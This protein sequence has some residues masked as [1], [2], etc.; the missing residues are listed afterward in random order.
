MHKKCVVIFGPTAV[1]KSDLAYQIA[2]YCKTEIISA[3]SRQCFRELNIGV[4][5]PDN[6]M[7]KNIPHHFV[8][9][10]SIHDTM[11][12]KVFF[13]YC[14]HTLATIFKTNDTAIIVGGTGFYID[15]ILNG[16]QDLPTIP[17]S[18]KQNVQHNVNAFGKQWLQKQVEEKDP[19]FFAYVDKE[20]T[21]R[22]QRALE[23][24]DATQQSI[25]LFKENKTRLPEYDFILL[26]VNKERQ[27]LYQQIDQRVEIMMKNG[28]LEE[29]ENLLQYQQIENLQTIGYKELFSFFNAECSLT[30]AIE[31]VK[32]HSRNYAKR[33]ITWF[34]RYTNGH[35]ITPNSSIEQLKHLFDMNAKS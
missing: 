15:A 2:Q 4:A 12:V 21:H 19:A 3:D 27:M 5:K 29:A 1:G 25:T 35:Y 20:N 9:S 11:N 6:A 26:N 22:L 24:F 23:F 30:T 18:I 8:N 34:N 10:H 13:D 32:Q 7:L 17:L 33:Q 16:I 31:K 28:L 14:K